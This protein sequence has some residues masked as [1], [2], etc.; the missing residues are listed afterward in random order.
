M[1]TVS[2]DPEN[3]R[4]IA[5]LIKE[6]AMRSGFDACGICK[7]EHTGRHAVYF[8]DWIKKK[9][10]SEMSFMEKHMDVR[11]NPCLLFD[12]AQ[13]V[14]VTALNYYPEQKQKKDAPQFAY[15]AYG[16][17]YHV[18]V[19]DKLQSLYRFIQQLISDVHGQICCDTAPILEKYHAMK[20]GLGWIGKNKQLILPNKGSY[21]F[22]GEIVIDKELSYDAPVEDQCGDCGL[23]IAACPTKALLPTGQLD[24]SRCLSYLTI[25]RK[26]HA[27]EKPDIPRESVYGCDICSKVC[28]CNRLATPTAVEQFKPSSEFLQL[29]ADQL[30]HMDEPAFGLLFKNSPVGRIGLERLKRNLRQF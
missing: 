25:E 29:T 20:A 16:E 21:F 22:L 24:A 4:P 14:I 9:Y 12:Q 5:S 7:A 28:P 2:P 6:E 3:Q 19:K 30:L 11:T 1:T 18:V 26:N 27:A 17:D 23:C 10:H 15:Y 8:H 13:T